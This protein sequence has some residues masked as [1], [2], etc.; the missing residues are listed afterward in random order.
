MYVVQWMDT[1]DT[2]KYTVRQHL[3]LAIIDNTLY[4]VH[5]YRF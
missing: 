4:L 5:G 2:A 1:G 3:I